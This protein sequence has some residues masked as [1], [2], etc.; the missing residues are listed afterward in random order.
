M[1]R[2]IVFQAPNGLEIEN[3]EL[4]QLMKNMI[5]EFPEYWQQGNGNGIL[6]FD[7]ENKGRRRL[8]ILPNAEFG[9]YLQYIKKD[10][11]KETLLSLFNARE[12]NRTAECGEKLYASIGLF[13]PKEQAWL[14]IEE[15][16]KTGEKTDQIDWISPG[17]IPEEGNW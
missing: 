15:F 5:H 9:I 13:L 12:L 16:C 6:D 3:P 1:A 7:D 17:A 2:R 10:D 11:P 4:Y 14:A 8:L